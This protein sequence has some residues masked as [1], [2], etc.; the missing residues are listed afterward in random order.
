M[1]KIS[2]KTFVILGPFGPKWSGAGNNRLISQQILDLRLLD[3]MSYIKISYQYITHPCTSFLTPK[4]CQR[5]S[6][7]TTRDQIETFLWFS[8]CMWFAN[9]SFLGNPP[10]LL[11]AAISI[12]QHLR[13][14]RRQLNNTIF[15]VISVHRRLTL[16]A[17]A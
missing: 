2:E 6:P 5:T 7:W 1:D 3:K 10:Q 14:N 8:E 16:W 15:V 17:L 11:T 13:V 9:V 12:Q 4:T